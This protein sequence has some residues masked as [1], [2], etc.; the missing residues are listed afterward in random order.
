LKAKSARKVGRAPGI[1]PALQKLAGLVAEQKHDAIVKTA[2]D[3]QRLLPS[4][5]FVLK[6]LSFGLLG[7]D[8]HDAALEVLQ[9]AVALTPDDPELYCN[10]GIA[11]S[12]TMRWP[13][14]LVSFER[15][16]A[17]NPSDPVIWKNMGSA[18]CHMNRWA[19]AIPC[20]LKAIEL[21][22]GD[23]DPTIE[24][25]ADALVH[26]GRAD[27][28]LACYMAL[29][30]GAPD[31]PFYLGSVIGAK[32]RLCEWSDLHVQVER[33][34][35]ISDGF[36]TQTMAPLHAMLVPDLTVAEL[37]RIAEAAI[38]KDIPAD[39]PAVVVGG[40]ASEKRDKLRIG[41]V[42]YD[43]NDHAVAHVVPQ[44]FELHD[45]SQF[46][47]IAYSLGPNDDSSIRH[48]LMKAVDRFVDI[49]G[50]GV[51]SAARCIA[52]DQI[53]VLVDLQGWT[54]GRQPGV[55]ALRPA[56]VHVNWLGFA[57]TI[58]DSRLVD[59]IIG[60]AVV[61]PEGEERGYAEHVVRLPYCYLPIDTLQSIGPEWTRGEAGLPN[62]AFV[63]S[64][65]NSCSKLNP[66][67]FDAWCAILRAT[68]GSVL[69]L[70]HAAER[71]VGN[72]RREAQA[73]GVDSQRLIFSERVGERSR[74]LS[75]LRLA[76][77][78]LDPSPYNSHSSGLDVLW[79]GVPMVTLLGQGFSG[80]VGASLLKAAGLPECVTHSW[81]EYVNLCISLH[82]ERQHLATLR[83]KLLA[84][85]TTAPL[86]DMPL[87]V[88]NLERLYVAMRDG[89]CQQSRVVG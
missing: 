54:T 7:Q 9:R 32:L 85:R 14:A 51:H 88:R 62:D 17:L 19:E 15:A 42:S 3:M 66:E 59:F 48:R 31:N 6:A 78:V 75:R 55:F 12:V 82:R 23:D 64:S 56:K 73:R 33:L 45:R 36:R 2:R 20:L 46:E 38:L 43:F 87:F 41:Y 24:Q 63:F 34:R 83:E 65:P 68:P 86:F 84:N 49:S 69:W 30:D 16:L 67:V 72:L 37:R 11:Q 50:M 61:I 13:D 26:D 80:R 77:L 60:D 53:D 25:L 28:A 10:M 39:L 57:G 40:G 29:L 18:F 76:D 70:A 71:I 22:P 4:H 35:A 58:G 81:A 47:V 79:A 5:P 21:F 27:E 1:P 8:H 44:V 74:Y 52:E 89:T